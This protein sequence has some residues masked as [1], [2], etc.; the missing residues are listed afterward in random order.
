[1]LFRSVAPKIFAPPHDW[2]GTHGIVAIEAAGYDVIRGRGAGLRNWLWRWEYATIFLRMFLYRFPH[3]IT[4][5][6]PLYPHVLD[7]GR[8]KEACSYRLEDVDVFQGLEQAA[9]ENG[10]FVVVAHLHFYTQEKK[11]KLAKLIE[12]ARALGA[13]F[14]LP[15]KLFE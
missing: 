2:I 3:F 14:V 10:V 8:H 13:E 1:M 6:P 12:R 5:S 7:F 9:K 11:D 4:W 15:S